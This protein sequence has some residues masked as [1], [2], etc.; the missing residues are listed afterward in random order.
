MVHSAW[1][2]VLLLAFVG[3]CES[4]TCAPAGRYTLTA[5]PA[6][7]PGNCPADLKDP[8]TSGMIDTETGPRACG[9]QAVDLSGPMVDAVHPEY[10]S[11]AGTM[12]ISGSSDGVLGRATVTVTPCPGA[13]ASICEASYDITSTRS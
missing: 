6:A 8:I 4:D 2:T 1:C 10:C 11:F 12:W 7:E 13:S 9:T 5:T 3:A